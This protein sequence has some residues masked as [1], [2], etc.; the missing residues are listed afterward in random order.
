[1]TMKESIS[2][3]KKMLNYTMMP[4]LLR[5]KVTPAIPSTFGI[6]TFTLY[7]ADSSCLAGPRSKCLIL[8]ARTAFWSF[9][10]GII[11]SCEKEI[12]PWQRLEL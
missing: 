1:M 4:E 5:Y 11:I 9:D 3:I 2:K 10:P 7:M 8:Q 12:E 6:R